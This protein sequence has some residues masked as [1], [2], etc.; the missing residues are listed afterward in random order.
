VEG[1]LPQPDGFE[2][3]ARGLNS[4]IGK[5]HRPRGTVTESIELD[6]AP[7]LV[8]TEPGSPEAMCADAK[9]ECSGRLPLVVCE[10]DDVQRILR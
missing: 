5:A 2:G 7:S 10:R 6:R 3:L 1:L 9:D 8:E 4:D